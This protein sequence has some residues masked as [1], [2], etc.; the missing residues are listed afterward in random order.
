MLQYFP[1]VNEIRVLTN[2]SE[3]IGNPKTQDAIV[4]H[5]FNVS[6]GFF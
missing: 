5:R 1:I 2:I 3:P 4:L 6:A